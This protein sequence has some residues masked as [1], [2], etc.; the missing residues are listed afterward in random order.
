[1]PEKTTRPDN[2]P[3][4][5]RAALLKATVRVVARLGMRGLT[6]RAVAQEAGVAHGLVAHH[7]GSRDALITAAFREDA[8]T[9]DTPATLNPGT[10]DIADIGANISQIV[11]A[12]SLEERYQYEMILESLRRPELIDDVRQIYSSFMDALARELQLVGADRV[13]PLSRVVFA[14]L[15]GLII[16]QLITGDAAA[17]ESAVER[18]QSLIRADIAVARLKSSFSNLD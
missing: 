17:T 3:D 8:R 9:H 4:G 7:F 13:E 6:Y 16:Q 10:G 18:L 14:T 1:M 12:H 2:A 15:D 5:G 11:A